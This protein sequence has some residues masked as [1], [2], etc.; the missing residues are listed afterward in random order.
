MNASSGIE[1]VQARFAC[2]PLRAYQFTV[3]KLS[4]SLKILTWG[5]S[6]IVN[7]VDQALDRTLWN[8]NRSTRCP[9][10][11]DRTEP[12]SLCGNQI[13]FMSAFCV[14]GILAMCS[15]SIIGCQIMQTI[16]LPLSLRYSSVVISVFWSII[17]CRLAQGRQHLLNLPPNLLLNFT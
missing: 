14:F 2:R 11:Q 6:K 9:V 12:H 8:H 4:N 5:A 17:V 13:R 15:G 16:V 10:K 1:L 3:A 7:L